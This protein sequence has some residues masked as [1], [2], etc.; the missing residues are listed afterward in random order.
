MSIIN[1]ILK[2]F[3]K[4]AQIKP[5]GEVDLFKDQ[6]CWIST[7]I[8]KL[9]AHLNTIGI[10]VGII[11]IRGESRG[12]KTTLS[13][14]LLRN[15]QRMFPE[16]GVPVI[17]STERR[18]NKP[19]AKKIGIDVDNLIIAQCKTI[20]DVFVKTQQIIKQTEDTFKSEGIKEKPKFMFVW[21]SIGA[22][23]SGQELNK[24]KESADN[25]EGD[26][27]FK[28][29]MGSAARALK[30]GLRYLQGEVFDK[31]IFFIAINHVYDSVNGFGGAGVKSY[32]GKG[33]EFM[34]NLRLSISR[35]NFVKHKDI[36]R[37][38]ESCIEIVKSDF[39]SNL[40]KLK[41]EI[42]FGSG[43]ILTQEELE[44]AVEH[45]ILQRKGKNGYSFLDGKLEWLSRGQ[46]YDIFDEGN[47][48]YNVL[49]RKITKKYHEEILR[50]RLDQDS[51][52]TVDDEE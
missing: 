16:I 2:G 1:K 17:L 31:D 26:D 49:V 35:T 29:A 10:P 13:L 38:Q 20:E 24:M 19:Y 8:P 33:I 37:G 22:S 7:G 9:D 11:E 43:F 15:F 27:Q 14:Q 25:D 36:K 5:L 41:V 42:S 51:K 30:R 40:D 52:S 48:M 39:T 3:D 6:S 50:N 46:L 47:P 12:G 45:N 34:P 18:D 32:G 4:N 21:D 44:F 23:I 28:A